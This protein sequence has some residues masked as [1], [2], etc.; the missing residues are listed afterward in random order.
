MR[1]VVC[2]RH[3]IQ[4]AKVDK[5]ID[6]R[7]PTYVQTLHTVPDTVGIQP[8]YISIERICVIESVVGG[9]ADQQG[10]PL[11]QAFQTQGPASVGTCKIRL[12]IRKVK[13]NGA[14]RNVRWLSNGPFADRRSKN[15]LPLQTTS[16]KNQV[17]AF[18]LLPKGYTHIYPIF[19]TLFMSAPAEVRI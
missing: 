3:Q 2:L 5:R 19:Y 8:L 16:N 13:S 6:V 1:Q 12:G 14:M 15:L 9:P 7:G 17:Q 4:I 18:F 11:L 10:S